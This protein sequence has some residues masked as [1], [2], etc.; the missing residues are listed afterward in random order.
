[1]VAPLLGATMGSKDP[2]EALQEDR[3]KHST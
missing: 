3:S 2:N 1:M